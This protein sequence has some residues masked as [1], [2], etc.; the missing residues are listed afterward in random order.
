MLKSLDCTGKRYVCFPSS[1]L[2]A[3]EAISWTY[4]A[5]GT[6]HRIIQ[7]VEDAIFPPAAN[8][9]CWK[10]Q[11]VV[12]IETCGCGNLPVIVSDEQRR[13]VMSS[14]GY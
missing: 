1:W 10:D 5:I 2:A 9:L 8:A 4:T 7:A 14:D 3:C 12:L 11:T 6:L 13:A